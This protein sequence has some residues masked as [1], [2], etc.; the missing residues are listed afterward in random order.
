MDTP[1]FAEQAG[2]LIPPGRG[3]P[4]G[5]R[6]SIRLWPDPVAAT[7]D[8][9]GGWSEW[10]PETDALSIG[11]IV[12]TGWDP[13]F[14]PDAVAWN[15]PLR[16]LLGLVP[17][18]VREAL[19]E[20]P[21]GC[22]WLSLQGMSAIPEMTELFAAD[23]VL[24]TML[25]TNRRRGDYPLRFAELRRRVGCRRR[26]LLA[27]LDLPQQ[28]WV[29]AVLRKT[30]PHTVDFPGPDV[31]RRVILDED[32]EVR[33]VLRH[34][35]VLCDGTYRTLDDPATRALAAPALLLDGVRMDQY[36]DLRRLQEHREAGVL[37]ARPRHFRSWERVRE[38]I[39]PTEPRYDEIW[40]EYDPADFPAPFQTPSGE[41][42]LLG[43]PRV[44][45][46][47]ILSAGAM[48][49]AGTI[50]RSCLATSRTY[51]QAAA[52]GRAVL[53]S[54]TWTQPHRTPGAVPQERMAS[55][56][57]TRTPYGWGVDQ[58][59]LPGNREAPAWLALRLER[60]T[61]GLCA[62][63]VDPIPALCAEVERMTSWRVI[64]TEPPLVALFTAAAGRRA[65]VRIWASVNPLTDSTVTRMAQQYRYGDDGLPIQVVIVAS[66]SGVSMYGH[67]EVERRSRPA[68]LVVA[69]GG[70]VAESRRVRAEDHALAVVVG[71][72]IAQQGSGA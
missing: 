26:D 66:H 11:T 68:V 50:M 3:W 10:E 47:P 32:R 9:E 38:M 12:D 54:A 57:L 14:P 8:A 40:D 45:L 58:L 48:I 63:G 51:P 37:P 22:W 21:G 67:E 36:V 24:A 59:A 27:L 56:W 46:V 34:A 62:P 72:A 7:Q 2:R 16:V 29:L 49:E 52:T 19:R 17:A 69:G 43:E 31:V 41:C 44:S 25:V 55:V 61:W 5:R 1:P 20:V 13:V 39:E 6:D 65:A 60:W 30:S 64:A 23:V 18:P 71:H 42:T 4:L 35:R 33:Q 28:E 70:V 15:P 53:I